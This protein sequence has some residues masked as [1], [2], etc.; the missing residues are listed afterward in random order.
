MTILSVISDVCTVVG[1]SVPST[2]FG[3]TEREH[4][5]LQSLANEMAKRIAFDTADWT[6]LKTLATLTGDGSAAS[7]S[8]PSD[9]QRMLK[10]AA[11]WPSATPYTPLTHI[12]DTD[13]WLAITVQQ[14]TPVVGAWT[15]IGDLLYIKP[16]VANAATV[17]F[18][19]ISNLIVHPATGS[20]KTDFTLDTDV[21][22][23]DERVLKLGMIWQWL[24][25]KGRP[26]AE[27]MQ[28]Y[29]SALASRIGEDK[30]SNIIVVGR[31]RIPSDATFAYPGVLGP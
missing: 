29:E 30:G 9:Y 31:R 19:Y 11:L 6:V 23:L 27:Q 5:E 18:Y 3:S 4:V 1:L 22:R 13:E 10:K 26:Y 21:F 16:T 28:E 24:A 8:K 7:F 17:K 2:V 25:N 15:M 14:F 12:P 20:N